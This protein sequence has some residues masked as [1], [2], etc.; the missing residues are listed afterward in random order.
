MIVQQIIKASQFIKFQKPS[1]GKQNIYKFNN[2]NITIE[3]TKTLKKL[4]PNDYNSS[5]AILEGS[6]L[7]KRKRHVISAGEIVRTSTLKILAKTFSISRPLVLLNVSKIE[8][9]IYKKN[10]I[11]L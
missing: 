10:N 9:K 3:K 4:N 1:L 6:L 2:L 7:D 5:T 8:N 11:I